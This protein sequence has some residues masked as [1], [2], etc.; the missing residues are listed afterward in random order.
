MALLSPL[1]RLIVKSVFETTIDQLAIVSGT[2]PIR[3]GEAGL[4]PGGGGDGGGEGGDHQ[5]IEHPNATDKGLDEI[6]PREMKIIQVFNRG[7]ISV[8]TGFLQGWKSRICEKN[9]NYYYYLEA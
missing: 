3:S 8:R 9:N 5:A 7:D 4:L 2:L 6:L 1:D